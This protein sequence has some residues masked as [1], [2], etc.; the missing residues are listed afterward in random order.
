MTILMHGLANE[1][2]GT[3]V[4]VSS[5]W[6]ATTTESHVTDKM[7]VP[8]N[9]MRDARLFGEAVY[10]IGAEKTEKYNGRALIDEDLMRELG[11]TEFSQYRIDPEAEPPRIMPRQFPSLRVAEEDEEPMDKSKLWKES[12][13]WFVLVTW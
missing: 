12:R 8:A 10:A 5:L 7:G 3:G 13:D 4:S 11:V 2:Q 1:L 9:M 6:P